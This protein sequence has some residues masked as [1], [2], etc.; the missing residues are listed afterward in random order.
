MHSAGTDHRCGLDQSIVQT[1]MIPLPM[2]MRNKLGYRS[3]EMAFSDRN[4]SLETFLLHRSHESLRVCIRVR[5]L[6][7]SLHDTNPRLLELFA[8]RHTPLCIPIA[9]QHTTR[10]CIRRR[11][12]PH[13][14]T[15]KRI[16]RI[17][18]RPK[19]L[20]AASREID[21]EHRVERHK[22]TPRPHLGG[23]E[24]SSGNCSPVRS[25]KRLPRRWA[26]RRG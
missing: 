16:V 14:L 8:Y 9:D 12:R 2:V 6:I 1:L 19:H 23:E 11:K 22:A 26:L 7:G 15:H 13:H 21:D 24:I 25:Q 20:N 3:S 10:A 5:S 4:D 18:C 17:R